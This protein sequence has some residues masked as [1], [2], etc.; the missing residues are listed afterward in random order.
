M[1]VYAAIAIL[2]TILLYGI[3]HIVV[4]SPFIVARRRTVA[5]V[6]LKRLAGVL[7]LGVL[8]A[9]VARLF[10]PFSLAEL[11]LTVEIPPSTWL[12]VLGAS[13]II[14]PGCF[15]TAHKAA[16]FDVYPEM[17]APEW[18]PGPVAANSISSAFYMFAYEFLFR[19]FL[20]FPCL[21]AMPAPWAIAINV[22][23]Y[24]LAH[25]PKGRREVL[26]SIPLGILVCLATI[27]TGS[28]WAAFLIHSVMS[29]LNDYLAVRA[30]PEM[31]FAFKGLTR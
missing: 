24:A 8:A 19:G 31:R 14:V 23:L 5:G 10:L 17:R 21:A 11:G 28:V 1:V 7:I 3:Y 4:S 9:G 16:N 2:A 6:I 26:G 25:V 18:G 22:A 15:A 29:Q 30:N 13:L 27:A 12:W 20:L